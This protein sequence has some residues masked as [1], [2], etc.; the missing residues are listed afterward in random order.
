LIKYSLYKNNKIY[1]KIYKNIHCIDHSLPYYIGWK[2]TCYKENTESLVV[3]SKEI[4]LEVNAEKTKY[5]VMSRNQ[6]A[7]Q[8]FIIKIDNKSFESVEEFKYLGTALTNRNSIQ[9]EIESR[10][11]SGNV[12]YDSVQDL[13][14]SSMLSKN[15]KFKIYRT[16]ILPVVLYEC[17]TLREEHRL[18]VFENRVLR[19]IFGRKRDEITGEWRR[20]H[21]EEL[22]DLNSSPNI[23]RVIKSRRMMWA[24]HVARMGE[25]RD[26]YRN[27]VGRPEGR[28]SL[29]RPKHRWE[30]NIK[31]KLQEVGWEHGLN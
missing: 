14:S 23:I 18:R 8:N 5:M 27:L 15:T 17:E 2:R 12:C 11:K 26:A 9:E 4:G 13:L 10:L 29:G 22:N 28:K 30:D 21:N 31:M 24:G 20:L 7:G 1:K 6:N 3:A 19:R 16:I 25:G